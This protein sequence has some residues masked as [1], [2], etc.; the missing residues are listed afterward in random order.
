MPR[1]FLHLRDNIDEVLDPEG[2]ILPE[3]AIAGA[4]LFAARDCISADV[5]SGRIDL[6]YRIDVHAEDGQIVH[7]ISFS[8]AIEIISAP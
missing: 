3:E 7:T 4:A 8:D 1:Y 6:H 2:M 5:K